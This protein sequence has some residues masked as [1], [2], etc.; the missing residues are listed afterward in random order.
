MGFWI[1][2]FI[3]N[4]LVPVTMI[5]FGR[6][7][8]KKPPKEINSIYGYRTSRSMKN[9]DTWKFAHQYFGKLWYRCGLILLAPSI[10]AMLFVIGQE[11]DTVGTAG[12]ILCF[13][14]LLPLIGTIFPTEI[15]LKKTFDQNGNRRQLP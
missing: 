13:L 9:K 3:M 11:E 7:F 8:L 12:G 15:A 1:F 10:A 5:G 6:V 2:M 14:Q 4:L